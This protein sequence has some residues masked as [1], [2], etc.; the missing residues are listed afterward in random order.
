MTIIDNSTLYLNGYTRTLISKPK[1]DYRYTVEVRLI[2]N[3]SDPDITSLNLTGINNYF[4][5]FIKRD[6][7][8]E[9]IKVDS[10]YSDVVSIEGETVK[11]GD[12]EFNLC[13]LGGYAD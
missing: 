13:V 4:K 3:S 5:L 1:D 9:I 8:D 11:S 7:Q 10:H 6:V 2:I 12:L